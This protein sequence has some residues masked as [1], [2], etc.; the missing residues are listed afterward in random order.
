[1]TEIAEKSIDGEIF[2][3]QQLA[4]TEYHLKRLRISEL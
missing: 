3:R 4:A 2:G 1:M